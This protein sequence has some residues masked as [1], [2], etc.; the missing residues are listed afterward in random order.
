[1]HSLDRRRQT[2][3]AV[4]ILLIVLTALC[5]GWAVLVQHTVA[6]ACSYATP[7]PRAQVLH[8]P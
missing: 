2:S 4:F 8:C 1:M 7:P 6:N 5:A 3:A